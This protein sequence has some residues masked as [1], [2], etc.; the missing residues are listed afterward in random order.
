MHHF[1]VVQPWLTS[2]KRLT[3]NRMHCRPLA[4]L[5]PEPPSRSA[6]APLPPVQRL[7]V[8]SRCHDFASILYDVFIVQRCTKIAAKAFCELSLRLGDMEYV[9]ETVVCSVHVCCSRLYYIL[10]V[11]N[12]PN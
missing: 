11:P 4:S 2:K 10:P 9:D 8:E 12:L 1:Q 3:A 7:G 5:S 6:H